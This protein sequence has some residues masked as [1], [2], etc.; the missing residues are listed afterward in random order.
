MR[1]GASRRATLLHNP[2]A[3][4]ARPTADDLKEILAEAGFQVRYR[5]TAKEWKKALADASDLVV[6]AGGDGTVAEVAREMAGRSV[7][8][9]LLPSGTAN[10]IARTLGIAGD[11]REIV[12][13]W[14]DAAPRPFDVG[15]VRVGTTRATFVE[16][17]GG[18]VFAAAIRRGSRD[19]ED[20]SA[21]VGGEI[22]RAVMLVRDLLDEARPER[23]QVTLDGRD[24]SGE[25]VAVEALN[26]RFIGPSVPLAPEADPG[27]GLF[28]VV[29]VAD[30]QRRALV[31]YLDRRIV[32]ASA[33][34]PVLP[35]HRAR[36]VVLGQPAGVVMHVDDE[37]LE[38]AAGSDESAA[39]D[40][41]ATVEVVVDAGA[42]SMM[43]GNMGPE[44][45]G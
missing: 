14:R 36:R 35:V 41:S 9:G 31:D 34:A 16:S 38:D 29:L 13:L 26:I 37:S 44:G 32:E 12:A 18:G 5:S 4:D 19:V 20:S 40:A 24:M 11:A 23:W 28:D 3:G 17:A 8:L 1:M 42:L 25:Y 2:S 30:E 6:A 39:G 21:L 33:V 43:P 22:D 10:N 7:P 27:D 45:G 15:R